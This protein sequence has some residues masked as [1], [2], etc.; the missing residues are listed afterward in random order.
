[1]DDGLTIIS[2]I[3]LI[4]SSSGLLV[5]FTLFMLN[6]YIPM[7]EKYL[8]S[9]KARI[10]YILIIFIV[11]IC[12]LLLALMSLCLSLLFLKGSFIGQLLSFISVLIA[13]PSFFI[14]YILKSYT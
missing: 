12:S 3:S 1:M 5:T 7:R 9:K 14:I 11:S 10:P 8:I 2:I 6:L 4:L 13:L